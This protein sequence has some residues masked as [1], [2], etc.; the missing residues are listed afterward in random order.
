MS[1]TERRLYSSHFQVEQD[2][3]A[4]VPAVGLVSTLQMLGSTD[5]RS[6]VWPASI[7]P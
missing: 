1:F 3:N 7:A 5:T 2:E 4:F 6:G